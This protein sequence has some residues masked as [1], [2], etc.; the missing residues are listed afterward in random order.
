VEGC[1]FGNGS[2]TVAESRNRTLN[3]IEEKPI[4]S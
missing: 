1:T 3:H 2:E 4:A